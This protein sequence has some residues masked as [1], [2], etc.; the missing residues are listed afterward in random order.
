MY[1]RDSLKKR[2]ATIGY[3]LGFG[4]KR[5]FAT[6]DIVEKTPV[7]F[8]VF[9]FAVGIAFLIF[10]NDTLATF[11]GA[12]SSVIGFALLYLNNYLNEKEKYIEIGKQLNTLYGKVYSIYEKSKTCQESE[13]PILENE[14]TLIND[15][16]QKIAIHKQV[17]FSNE[18]AHF[19]LFF[20]SQPGWF[21]KELQLTFWKDMIP[22][23]WRVYVVIVILLIGI[24]FGL[25]NSMFIKISECFNAR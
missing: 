14:L 18:F 25:N 4:S 2:S 10:K 19:K 8:G 12:S 15:E 20:E 16:F 3:N 11:I 13:F 1:T 24:Y 5:H 22:A 17:F 9:S 23:I 7:Y 21:V 6:Y